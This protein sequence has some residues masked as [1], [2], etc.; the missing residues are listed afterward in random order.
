MKLRGK[1]CD[2]LVFGYQPYDN[3][4]FLIPW[5]RHCVFITIIRGGRIHTFGPDPNLSKQA[6]EGD[7]SAWYHGAGTAVFQLVHHLY[8]CDKSNLLFN[9]CLLL[10]L[11]NMS[12]RWLINLRISMLEEEKRQKFTCL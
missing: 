9:T 12:F 7:E 3:G 10:T 2:G 8:W 5:V 6:K 4:T 1:D 11:I